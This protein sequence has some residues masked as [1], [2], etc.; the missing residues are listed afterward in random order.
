V[1]APGRWLKRLTH[2]G[3]APSPLNA[4]T[5]GGPKTRNLQPGIKPNELFEELRALVGFKRFETAAVA[6][7]GIELAE[8]IKKH[9]FDLKPF[10]R[11]ATTAPEMWAA[12]LAA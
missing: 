1:C 2:G 6:I 4:L 9:Q 10:T 7:R 11:N 3:F 8:K 12:V 5:G